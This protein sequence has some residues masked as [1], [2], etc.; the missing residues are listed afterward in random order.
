[1]YEEN[2]SSADENIL[3]MLL[4]MFLPYWPLFA[5]LIP[6]CFIGAWGYLK[7]TTPV[8][9][10]SATL[11]IKD[12]NKGVDDA[13]VLEAMN[14]FDS[15][16]IVE[17]E[18]EIIKSR[19]IMTQ[20][21]KGLQ[22]YAPFYEDKLYGS[23]EAYTTS[24][25]AVEL[26]N[27]ENIVLPSGGEPL[28]FYFEYDSVKNSVEIDNKSYPIGEWVEGPIFGETRFEL[29]ENKS[30]NAE[31]AIYYTFMN[32]KKLS[33]S[34][35]G[36]LEASPTDKLS[37]VVRLTYR[38]P[39]PQRGENILNHLIAAYNQKAI[40]DRDELASNTLTFIDERMSEVEKELN[41]LESSIQRFRS[42]KGVVDLSEQGKLYLYD[43]GEY[44]RQI[45][46]IDRQL[47]VLNKVQQYVI[48]KKNQSGIVPS[49]LGVEDRVLS[50]LL[51]KLYDSEVE[52]E[53]LRKTTAENN[54]I[55]TSLADE[56]NKIRP[57]ILENIRNQ[58]NNLTTSLS[59]LNSNADQSA[60]ALKNIPEKER[61]LLEIERGKEIKNELYSFLQQKRE[62]TALSYAPN[63]GDGR[64]VDLAQS[65][66]GP[67]S[68]NSSLIYLVALVLAFGIGLGYIIFKEMLN[69]NVLF[70]SEIENAIDAPVV[71]ELP[72]LDDVKESQKS[73]NF[74]TNIFYRLGLRNI[75]RSNRQ[76]I[77]TKQNEAVLIHHFRQLGSSMGLYS[78]VFKKKKILVTS[79]IE[80]EGKSFVSTNLSFS[81]AQ[82]GK[83]VALVDM[84]FL[85]PQTSRYFKLLNQRG[86]LDYL[87]HKAEYAKI[88]TNSHGN[89]NLYI[90][91]VGNRVDDH[92]QLLLNGKLEVLFKEL[93]S[94]FDYVIIDSAPVN[95]VA[96]VKLLAEYSDETIYV[97][98]HGNTP[99][100]ILKHLDDSETLENLNNVSVVFN[101]IKQRG[102]VK[103]DYNYGY[104]LNTKLYGEA[105][106]AEM[107]SKS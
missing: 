94:D 22:L 96:D 80:G 107:E 42:E 85:K 77:K 60:S 52:Y 86:V 18:L 33:I 63:G 17:N 62:E 87:S 65:S 89:K 99:L 90:V 91:P 15:K 46:R 64:I 101:G 21:V 83:K 51:E 49:T 102:L 72:H 26:R 82:S 50:Q 61:A 105:Y 59:S 3:R 36:S 88:L 73:T 55:L 39:I 4:A 67:V 44:D 34:L 37:T 19:T 47:A 8:Y 9:E 29:N 14:P 66:A 10:A 25:I 6:V 43:V 106:G 40:S 69:K 54:P 45:A 24:P 5:L 74:I 27:P 79:S 20:V 104:G 7:T 38:D 92:T 100:K 12:E 31:R 11:I 48:S 23:K 32:P 13:K 41:A 56:I 76:T 30:E 81:L 53:K 58:K 98:R 84:D 78:R 35:L 97:I 71:L 2:K 103:G 16:K 70:R 68:P 93:S 1:M 75:L 95:L 57:S 28:K